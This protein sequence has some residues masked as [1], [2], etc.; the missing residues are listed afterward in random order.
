MAILDLRRDSLAYYRVRINGLTP[1]TPRRWGK[2]EPARLLCH[3]RRSLEI[4]LGEIEN[5]A[6]R[7]IPLVRDG[8]L[9]VFFHSWTHWPGG[10]INSGAILTPK[11]KQKFEEE[12]AA[13]HKKLEAFVDALEQS[14]ERCTV[15]PLLGSLSLATWSHVHGVHFHHHF[16][17]FHLGK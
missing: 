7:S 11:P 1:T 13:L 12:R 10:W 9:W 6:D 5:V 17:Q 8:L 14:P 2:L 3:L 4:S 15:H 16:R